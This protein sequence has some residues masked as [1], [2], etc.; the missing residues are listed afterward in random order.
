M[1]QESVVNNR[2][3]HCH[4]KFGLV[5]HR[6]AFKPFCSKQCLDRY[7]VCRRAVRTRKVWL[8]CLLALALLSAPAINHSR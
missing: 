8:D 6:R 7:K 3:A 2:C 4:G 5:R 1:N